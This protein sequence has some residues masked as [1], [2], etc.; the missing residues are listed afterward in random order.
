MSERIIADETLLRMIIT[1]PLK[2]WEKDKWLH[3]GQDWAL[4]STMAQLEPIAALYDLAIDPDRR[5]ELAEA[6]GPYLCTYLRQNGS[7][8]SYLQL[9]WF[10]IGA[11]EIHALALDDEW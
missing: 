9:R 3:F 2:R 6:L 11:N 8:L 4:R 10:V 1:N 5:D 7:N